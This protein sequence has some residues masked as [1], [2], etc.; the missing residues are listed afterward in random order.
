MSRRML[1]AG[2]WKM[3]LTLASVRSLIEG[4]RA[5]LDASSA[6]VDIAVCPTAVYLMPARKAVDGSPIALGA[7]NVYHEQSGAFTGEI[8]AE[9]VVDAGATYAILGHSERRHTIGHHE[10]DRMINLKVRATLAAGLTPI[11]C[12]GETLDERKANQTADVLTYQM[13]AGLVGVTL[14]DAKQLVIA[15]E[16]VWAIGTGL[17]ATPQQ[18]QEAHQHIRGLLRGQ[19][20]GL[21]DGVRILYGGSLKPENAAEILTQPDVDGG[22]VGGASLKAESFLGIVRAAART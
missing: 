11:L 20:G 18:A 1:I 15:Y 21:A 3:N 2:N 4:I 14:R 22:L 19:F 13:T 17:N 6:K 7:Q 8:S 12:V 9:M 10:D 16:P 5:G